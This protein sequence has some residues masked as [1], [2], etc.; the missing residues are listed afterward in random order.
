MFF[1]ALAGW[2]FLLNK[3]CR[4]AMPSLDLLQIAEGLTLS[5]VKAIMSHR[6]DEIGSDSKAVEAP[7]E[8]NSVAAR[9]AFPPAPLAGSRRRHRARFL[10]ACRHPGSARADRVGGATSPDQFDG[11]H[12]RRRDPRD[13]GHVGVRLV[14]PVLQHPRYPQPGRVL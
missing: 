10:S 13:R 14:V 7:D 8:G 4:S 5:M 9:P 3:N 6:G 11:D 12:A 1:A 2:S